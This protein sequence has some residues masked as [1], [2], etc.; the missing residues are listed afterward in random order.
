MRL[1][2][3]I[4]IIVGLAGCGKSAGHMADAPLMQMFTDGPPLSG[5]A[6][7]LTYPDITVQPGEENTQCIWLNLSNTAPI[8]VHQVHNIL[9]NN[10]HHLIV[11]KDDM[12]TT[13]QTTPVNC[14]PFSGALNS[15]GKI[16]PIVITQ[17]KD[18]ELTLPDT[19]AYT[20]AAGQ[21]IKLEMHYI[22]TT[23]TASPANAMVNFFAADPSTIQNEAG[24]LF[25]GSLDIDIGSNQT[26]MLHEFIQ[27][28]SYMDLSKSNIFAITGHEHH[29][30]TGVTVNVGPGSAGP[31]TSIYNPQPFLW[32]EP[33]T[34]T[35]NTPFSVPYGG[36]FDLTCTWDNTTSSAVKFGESANDEMCF[37]WAYYYPAL[38]MVNNVPTSGS[39]VCLHTT[40]YGGI[41]ACCPGDSLCSLI[42]MGF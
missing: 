23:E 17:K 33:A 6:F 34:A 4:V 37:F 13:E 8:K 5:S 10:T 29:L 16:E 27:L 18:D 28:P 35:F 12:D 39:E 11:Y 24:V 3:R 40:Q 32:A 21:M 20:L 14:Q 15:T 2:V 19:V 42:Q 30:G 25:N 31:L 7:T 38:T 41:N 26:A 36:G 9:S 22:N 1:A